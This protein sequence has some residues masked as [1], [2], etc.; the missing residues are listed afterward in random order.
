MARTRSAIKV[1]DGVIHH[2]RSDAGLQAEAIGQIG[3]DIE[4]AAA[5]V[6][7]ALRC[8]SKRDDARVETMDKTANRHEVEAPSWRIFRP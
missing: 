8:L 3:G 4:F 7:V 2:R 6:N 1:A 5:D